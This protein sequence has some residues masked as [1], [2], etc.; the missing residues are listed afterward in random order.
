MNDVIITLSEIKVT[1]GVFTYC[2]IT[3]G[4]GGL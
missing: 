3:E 2:T 1:K 4:G